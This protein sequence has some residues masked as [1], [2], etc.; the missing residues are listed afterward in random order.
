MFDGMPD[1][2]ARARR[3][4]ENELQRIRRAKMSEAERERE[5]AKKREQYHQKYASDPVMREKARARSRAHREANRESVKAKQRE[6]Y[7]ANRERYS[8]TRKL[9]RQTHPEENKAR[10]R[11]RYYADH[12][13]TLRQRREMRKAQTEEQKEAERK[14]SRAWR[15]KNLARKRATNALWALRNPE[16]I[17]ES[18]ARWLERVGR[19][20]EF[21]RSRRRSSA[22]WRMANLDRAK[23]VGRASDARRRARIARSNGSFTHSEVVALGERQR[24]RCAEQ[25]CRVNIKGEFHCDHIVPLAKGGSNHIHNIQ[26]LC[27]TCNRRKHAKDPLVWA[28]Q[29]G[30]LL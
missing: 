4:R 19:T 1:P 17:L 13:E 5:R 16:K 2:V 20:E 30:R 28:R 25:T 24:W 10:C 11:A 3:E 6:H 27:P 8:E 29:N 26:L 15:Q 21:R 7:R 22:K 18:R 14:R 23:A 12:G 9:R